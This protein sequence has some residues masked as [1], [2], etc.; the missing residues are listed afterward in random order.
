MSSIES[1]ASM[2][3]GVDIRSVQ[4]HLGY[5]N[6]GTT[7]TYLYND[8]D[9]TA[10]LIRH[11]RGTVLSEQHRIS[12]AASELWHQNIRNT[13]QFYDHSELTESGYL[14]SIE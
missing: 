10:Y 3:A 5:S 13:N 8:G 14:Q 2:P 7:M 6:V 4:K 12:K 11:H 1:R 9:L